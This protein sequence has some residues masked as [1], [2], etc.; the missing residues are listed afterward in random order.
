VY[1]IFEYR[2]YARIWK[3]L[4]SKNGFNKFWRFLW[5][6]DEKKRRLSRIRNW[7]SSSRN[8]RR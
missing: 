1:Y 4:R 7:R 8:M 5:P 2:P 6:R 3:E